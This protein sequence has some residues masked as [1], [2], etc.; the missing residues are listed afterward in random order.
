MYVHYF[1]CDWQLLII[2]WCKGQPAV[3]KEGLLN[4]HMVFY[5]LYSTCFHIPSG[6]MCSP[7]WWHLPFLD[8]NSHFA[9]A[10][11]RVGSPGMVRSTSPIKSS[12][13][14]QF[15]NLL[16]LENICSYRLPSKTSHVNLNIGLVVRK[17]INTFQ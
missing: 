17:A 12:I 9:S 13:S 11:V 15:K 7:C 2:K 10:K 1:I 4:F 3:S 5:L 14:F 6:G 16:L 8:S